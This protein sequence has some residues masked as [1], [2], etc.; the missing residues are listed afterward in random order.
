M[1]VIDVK[2]AAEERHLVVGVADTTE[3]ATGETNPPAAMLDEEDDDASEDVDEAT[4]SGEMRGGTEESPPPLPPPRDVRAAEGGV[5]TAPQSITKESLSSS[6][7]S[8]SSSSTLGFG[9]VMGISGV[10]D[11]SPMEEALAGDAGG[12]DNFSWRL[13]STTG[14]PVMLKRSCSIS[15]DAI[16][17]ISSS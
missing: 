2:L 5:F 3:V 16:S 15:G 8:S 14:P 11:L 1:F 13:I 6:S 12:L 4:P 17:S 9:A 10:V 7:S